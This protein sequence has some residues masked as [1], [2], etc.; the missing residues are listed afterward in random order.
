[1]AEA[2]RIAEIPPAF[3]RAAEEPP[4]P[5]HD[6]HWREWFHGNDREPVSHLILLAIPICLAV[7]GVL[8]ILLVLFVLYL[9]APVG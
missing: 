1:V 8:H 4:P 6:P 9:S 5:P 3:Y 7:L 2:Q